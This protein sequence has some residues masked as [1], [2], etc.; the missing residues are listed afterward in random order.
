[1]SRSIN[2][3]YDLRQKNQ[4]LQSYLL[5]LSRHSHQNTPNFSLTFN[6]ID[7]LSSWYRASLIVIK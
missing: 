3:S 5:E 1:M 4:T 6:T 7:V 2:T